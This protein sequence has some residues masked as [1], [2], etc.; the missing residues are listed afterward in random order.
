MIKASVFKVFLIAILLF[1]GSSN[2]NDSKEEAILAIKKYYDFCMKSELAT[3]VDIFKG[4]YWLPS[5]FSLNTSRSL[6]EG[7]LIYSNYCGVYQ[8]YFEKI[9][10]KNKPHKFA[11]IEIGN[12]GDC[13]VCLEKDIEKL[14]LTIN[15]LSSVVKVF[16]DFTMTIVGI[17]HK[18][19]E[20]YLLIVL[21]DENRYMHFSGVSIEDVERGIL[22]YEKFKKEKELHNF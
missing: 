10:K 9:F 7:K 15:N 18:K 14:K 21:Y 11:D 13:K 12:V 4:L 3:S 17:N 1:S 20:E 6:K 19:A 16:E 22:L 2:A 5:G 8:E